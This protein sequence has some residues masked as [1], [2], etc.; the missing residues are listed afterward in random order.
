MYFR[1]HTCMYISTLYMYTRNMYLINQ[2]CIILKYIF[3]WFWYLSDN[4]P[5]L[6]KH[7]FCLHQR[8]Q[9]DMLISGVL[10]PACV[11]VLNISSFVAITIPMGICLIFN[12]TNIYYANWRHYVPWINA[13][14]FCSYTLKTNVISFFQ[15]ITF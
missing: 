9:V 13:N 15:G 4:P 6:L 8:W 10:H 2:L 5:K 3:Y 11:M 12:P 14:V 1:F 7:Y